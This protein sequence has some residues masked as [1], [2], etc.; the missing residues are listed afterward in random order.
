[1][2]AVSIALPQDRPNWTRRAV[3]MS[4]ALLGSIVIAAFRLAEYLEYVEGAAR[5]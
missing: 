4:A 1:M 5:V 3:W 2:R